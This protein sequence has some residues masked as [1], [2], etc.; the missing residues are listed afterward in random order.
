MQNQKTFRQVVV[1]VMAVGA[2]GLASGS[3][4]AAV[5]NLDEEDK[6]SPVLVYAKE[7]LSTASA[8]VIKNRTAGT[9]HYVVTAKVDAADA[10]S[11]NE[12][13]VS[14]EVGVGGATGGSVVIDYRFTNML[15]H[16]GVSL[17]LG[18][19]NNPVVGGTE[20]DDFATF[21]V[22]RTSGAVD[23]AATLTLTGG[24]VRIMADAPAS[25]TMTSSLRVSGLTV[26]SKSRTYPNANHGEIGLVVRQHCHQ[27]HVIR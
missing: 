15:L 13:M 14:G 7:A 9:T 5:I 16:G 1:T 17:E 10:N 19:D 12:L 20:G 3:A 22:A 21:I 27:S 24:V 23:D 18:G 8:N 4:L 25:V 6:S 26:G 11:L 2:L